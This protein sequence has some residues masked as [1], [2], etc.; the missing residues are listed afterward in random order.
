MHKS[1]TC[2]VQVGIENLLKKSWPKVNY[3]N[4][5]M[6]KKEQNKRSS[7]GLRHMRQFLSCLE[8]VLM[9]H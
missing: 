1:Y 3:A 4:I 5:E 2:P 8:W 7:R 9:L 6:V